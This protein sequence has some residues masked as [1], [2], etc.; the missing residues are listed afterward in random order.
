VAVTD[1]YRDHAI[2]G[3]TREFLLSMDVAEGRLF[4]GRDEAVAGSGVDLAPGASFVPAH[5]TAADNIVESRRHD[6]KLKIVGRLAPS[7]T[8]WDRAIV[9]PIESVWAMHRDPGTD[10]DAH[11]PAGRV[12]AVVV[13]PRSVSDAY[14]LRADFRK[15]GTTALFPAEALNP[16]YRMLGD[17]RT[18]VDGM[19]IA[20]QVLVVAAVILALY[21]LL[22]TRRQSL[23]VLRALGAPTRFLFASVWLQA[24]ALLAGG[25]ALGSLVAYGGLHILGRQVTAA[26]GLLVQPALGVPEV[27][28]MALVLVTGSAIAAVP[29]ALALR[30]PVAR[31][32]RGEG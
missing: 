13:T 1:S 22:A 25:A 32:L 20:F 9:V 24:V 8:P 18:I 5:G 6:A 30:T 3:T 11:S 28:L 14:A 12:P 26:T 4:A 29:A 21:S 27:G 16:L 15:N 17:A 23:G 2:V 7:G 31:L 19:S 10:T